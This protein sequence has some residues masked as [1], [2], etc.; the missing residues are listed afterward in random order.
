MWRE[1]TTPLLITN[2]SAANEGDRQAGRAGNPPKGTADLAQSVPTEWGFQVLI[3]WEFWSPF[4]QE[5]FVLVTIPAVLE[6]LLLFHPDASAEQKLISGE[7]SW[8]Q[9]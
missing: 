5:I 1:Q 2:I 8:G 3:L 4:P 7:F 6:S 9:D